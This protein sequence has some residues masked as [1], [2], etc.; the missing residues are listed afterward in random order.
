MVAV[1]VP[2]GASRA[3]GCALYEPSAFAPSSKASGAGVVESLLTNKRFST[4]LSDEAPPERC[5]SGFAGT[6]AAFKYTPAAIAGANGMVKIANKRMPTL[7]TLK[8]LRGVGDKRF[9]TSP[10]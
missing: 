10:C 8:K 2:A 6:G 1:T 4:G 9:I 3:P 7:R 5:A